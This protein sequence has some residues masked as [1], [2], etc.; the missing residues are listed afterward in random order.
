MDKK[1]CGVNYRDKE[2]I[3]SVFGD[4]YAERM[5]KNLIEEWA[6]DIEA[7]KRQIDKGEVP[8][9]K[10]FFKRV[11]EYLEQAKRQSE[12]EVIDATKQ[13]QAEARIFKRVMNAKDPIEGILGLISSTYE[14]QVGGK[15]SVEGAIK[16]REEQMTRRFVERLKN[17][18]LWEI[19]SDQTFANDIS[20]A[21]TALALGQDTTKI[22]PQIKEIAKIMNSQKNI[23][24]HEVRASGIPVKYKENYQFKQ[25]HHPTKIR[26]ATFEVWQKD[27]I[28][29]GLDT[30]KI[31]SAKELEELGV[32]GVMRRQYNDFIAGKNA[33]AERL[34]LEGNIV[35]ID[36][37]KSIGKTYMEHRAYQFTTPDGAMRYNA[38][39]GTQES[40][41]DGMLT[42]IKTTALKTVLYETLGPK[43]LLTVRKVLDSAQAEFTRNGDTKRSGKIDL[44]R[45]KVENTLNGVTGAS[46]EVGS[47]AA[48]AWGKVWRDSQMNSKL[49]VTGVRSLA[50]PANMFMSFMGTN[51][52]G[53]ARNLADVAWIVVTE[54]PKEYAKTLGNR[55]LRLVNKKAANNLADTMLLANEFLQREHRTG[56][57]KISGYLVDLMMDINGLN[58]VN[59]ALGKAVKAKTMEMFTNYVDLPWEKLPDAVKADVLLMDMDQFEWSVFKHTKQEIFDSKGKSTGKFISSPEGFRSDA[60][61]KEIETIMAFK[62]IK[63]DPKGIARRLEN[64]Y[65]S[66][67]HQLYDKVT[68]TASGRS[69]AVTTQGTKPG[70]IWGELLRNVM[71]YKGFT[72][73]ALL[74]TKTFANQTPDPKALAEGRLETIRNRSSYANMATYGIL[75]TALPYA[76]NSLYQFANG[77]ER[78]DLDEFDTYVKSLGQGPMGGFYFDAITG[79]WDKYS[80]VETAGGPIAGFAG[81]GMRAW[82]QAKNSL[83]EGTQ[84]KRDRAGKDAVMTTTKLV[85][86]N[87]PFQQMPFIKGALDYAENQVVREWL[88]GEGTN[89]RYEAKVAREKM[90]EALEE[91]IDE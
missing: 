39:Y 2:F 22:D 33:G 52:K 57:G 50:N 10:E 47:E 82:A 6:S 21:R 18:G 68:T 5:P 12:I 88:Y 25:T 8:H 49:M 44:W 59:T 86:N 1:P 67:L 35:G 29:F 77:K 20:A 71:Q 73:E 9:S 42:E 74:S 4:E 23:E 43:P 64:G 90:R 19:A 56:L 41:M 91:G 65:L 37:E 81:T 87:L 84:A 15:Y 78:D 38:K 72:F 7:I 11:D 40:L 62:G 54:V 89:A 30:S 69:Y 76:A 55:A 24:F 3:K 26:E 79:P 16:G 58:A 48:A 14:L 75:A 32:D 46:A 45:T 60:A 31:A 61:L 66:F 34:N 53:I 70:T 51:N 63:G 17:K 80:W 27:A 83:D 36:S 85:R 13:A 28:E